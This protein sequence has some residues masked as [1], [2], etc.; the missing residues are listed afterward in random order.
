M[1]LESVLVPVPGPL[2]PALA[3]TLDELP[4]PVSMSVYLPNVESQLRVL[5]S[6]S[7]FFGTSPA[8]SRHYLR[9]TRHLPANRGLSLNS[10]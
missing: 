3:E 9:L 4:A 5:V 1:G 2:T 7:L 6:S 10:Y 8:I